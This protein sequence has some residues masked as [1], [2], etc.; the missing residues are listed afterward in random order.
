MTLQGQ[1]TSRQREASVKQKTLEYLAIGLVSIWIVV[2]FWILSS[3]THCIQNVPISE[4]QGVCLLRRLAFVSCILG[5]ELAFGL[6]AGIQAKARGYPFVMGFAL[7]FFLNAI[8]AF[9]VM[10]LSPKGA[11]RT[12]L[13]KGRK[14]LLIVSLLGLAL[15]MVVL[16]MKNR[17][18]F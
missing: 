6:G 17:G 5:L 15:I 9:F 14:V 7:G 18:V 4:T 13:P 3:S 1:E 12:P 11:P 10:T 2:F 8:G 16:S